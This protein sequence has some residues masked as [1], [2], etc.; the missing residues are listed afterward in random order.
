M[1]TKVLN[2]KVVNT[3]VLEP[4]KV[5]THDD[6]EVDQPVIEI[7]RSA[8]EQVTWFSKKGAFIAFA[9]PDS[10]PFH[11]TTFQIP[12]GGSVSS[13][14]ARPNAEYKEYKYTVVGQIGVNDPRVIINP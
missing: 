6:G 11:A 5:H 13:G 1:A 8:K 10:S 4:H 7:S 9:S 14:P 12:A 3:K 2:T